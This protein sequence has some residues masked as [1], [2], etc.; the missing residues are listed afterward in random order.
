MCNFGVQNLA[1]LLKAGS[2]VSNQMN[3]SLLWRGIE[4]E[5]VPKCAENDIGIFTY[6]S[7][8]HGLLSGRYR[9]LDEFP[10]SR[11]RSLHFSSN[12]QGVNHGQ[13]GQEKL[14]TETLERIR[15]ICEEAGHSMVDAA[16]GWIVHRDCI[17]SVLAGSRTPRQVKQNAL[18]ASIEFSEDFLSALAGATDELK[19]AFGGHADMWSIPGRIH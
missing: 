5:I 2:V 1:D 19:N 10:D 8:L 9:L 13:K 15:K 7:L 3:Y 12:R 6:S 11:A 14:T 18:A 17:T 16:F 4:V